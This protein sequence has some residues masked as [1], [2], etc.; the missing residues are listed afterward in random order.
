M[1]AIRISSKRQITLPSRL[2]KE[3]GLG[4]HDWIWID[5]AG[6]ELRLR[7]VPEDPV[8]FFAGALSGRFHSADEVDQWVRA[9]RDS[10][11]T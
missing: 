11:R 9:E 7:K 8:E 3:V 4:P 6:G 2:A 1:P 5:A 10:W